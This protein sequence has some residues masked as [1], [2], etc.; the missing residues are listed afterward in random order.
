M[1]IARFK[2]KDDEDIYSPLCERFNISF[3]AVPYTTFIKENKIHALVGGVIS[4]NEENKKKFIHEVKKDK[5][6]QSVE[7]HNDFIFVHATHK[8]SRESRAEIKIFYN[9]E[10]IRVKPVHVSGDGWEYWE[11]ACLDRNELN[12]LIDAAEKYYHGELFS[13]KEEKLKAITSLTITPNLTDKQLEALKLAYHEGYYEYPR[14]LTINDLSKRLKK[15]Y[16]TFQE[17]LRKAEN[18]LIDYFLKYR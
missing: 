15:S 1:W 18:K 3:Y 5:R 8:L 17:H 14:T 9:P 6:V 2:L 4:G 11:V 13:V 12:K 10:Y 16:S 7:I